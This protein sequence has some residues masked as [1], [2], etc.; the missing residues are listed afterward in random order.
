MDHKENFSFTYSAAQQQEIES[1]RQ[2][3][4]PREESKLDRLRRLHRSAEQKADALAIL[5]GIL[6]ALLLGSGMSLIMTDIGSHL[7]FD[8]MLLGIPLGLSGLVLA[9]LAYPLHN[10]VLEKERQRIAPEILQLT[11]EL[12][13]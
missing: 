5:L 4:L 10:R 2:A 1:I 6:G 7:P 12:L 11:D 13:H 8:A 3:Y 9:A